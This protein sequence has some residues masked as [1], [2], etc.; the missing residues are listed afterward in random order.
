M[1]KLNLNSIKHENVI[2]IFNTIVRNQTK[3][4]R[5]DIAADTDLSIMTVGKIVDAFVNHDILLQSKEVKGTSGRKAGLVMLNPDRMGFIIDLTSYDFSLSLIDFSMNLDD[6]I[7]YPYNPEYSYQQNLLLFFR[8]GKIYCD[9][10]FNSN[11]RYYGAGLILPGRYNPDM[12][13]TVCDYIP[14]L[15]SIK[16][17]STIE[18]I[19]GYDLIHIDSD[20]DATARSI[21]NTKQYRENKCNIIIHI[22]INR[23]NI[24]KAGIIFNGN[25]IH[26][27]TYDTGNVGEIY[28]SN[29]VKLQSVINQHQKLDQCIVEMCHLFHNMI[30]LLNPDVVIIECDSLKFSSDIETKIQNCLIN[31]YKLKQYLMP[32]FVIRDNI[33]KHSHHGMAIKLREIWFENLL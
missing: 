10:K 18:E 33:I 5:S 24:V 3:I 17:K 8:N 28:V 29:N 14:E 23:Q 1:D 30:T 21:V 11:S 13:S 19:I 2:N 20:A 32:T 12:D 9:K 25:V 7:I 27:A 22:Y 4:S 31:D 15:E 16:I 26:G 6:K